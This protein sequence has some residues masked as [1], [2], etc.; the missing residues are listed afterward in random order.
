VELIEDGS[1]GSG[2][3]C[4]AGES[5]A[6]GGFHAGVFSVE[7]GSGAEGE[8]SRRRASP[9]PVLLFDVLGDARGREPMLGRARSLATDC[10]TSG[11]ER[12]WKFE[13]LIAPEKSEAP[14]QSLKSLQHQITKKQSFPKQYCC[15]PWLSS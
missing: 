10:S 8:C 6:V 9:G 2:E 3:G 12:M 14:R 4:G 13:R 7:A 1:R 15:L 5:G 11:F